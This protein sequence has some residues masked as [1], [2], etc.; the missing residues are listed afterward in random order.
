MQGAISTSLYDYGKHVITS[1]NL[2]KLDSKFSKLKTVDGKS[3]M[4]NQVQTAQN[5]TSAYGGNNIIN[6]TINNFVIATQSSD[7]GK[8]PINYSADSEELK[9]IYQNVT[10]LQK[11]EILESRK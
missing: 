3:A 2:G 10:P 1:L 11:E 9:K 5:F 8:P 7:S 4:S 6:N